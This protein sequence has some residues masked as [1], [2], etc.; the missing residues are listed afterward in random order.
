MPAEPGKVGCAVAAGA[1]DL[2][3]YP[4][5]GDALAHTSRAQKAAAFDDGADLASGAVAFGVS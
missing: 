2:S 5:D 4:S 3:I 1:A